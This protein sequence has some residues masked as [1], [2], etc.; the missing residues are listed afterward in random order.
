MKYINTLSIILGVAFLTSCVKHEVIPKPIYEA[1]LPIS[2]SGNIQGANYTIIED[3]NGY[4]CLPSQAI[5]IFPSPQ[6]STIVYYSSLES[7]DASVLEKI[8][9]RL[10]KLIFN[11]NSSDRPSIEDFNEFFETGIT[12][13]ID[14]KTGSDDGVEVIFRDAQGIEWSSL[15]GS[16]LPQD[17]EI[18]NFEADT[19]DD[20]QYMRFVARFNLA[21]YDNLID[22]ILSDTIYI[23]NAI[24]EGYFQR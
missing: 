10:G 17:F 23:E 9:V 1:S 13:P 11:S 8:E 7:S 21:L 12:T 24:F 15:E 14:Y 2:F 19:D 4:Y 16:G 18:S 3:I 22:P 20:G 5:E 6:P